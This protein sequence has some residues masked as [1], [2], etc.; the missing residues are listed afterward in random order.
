MAMT[1][2]IRLTPTMYSNIVCWSMHLLTALL[3]L[4][5]LRLHVHKRPSALKYH[6]GTR[7]FVHLQDQDCLLVGL[8]GRM[9]VASDPVVSYKLTVERMPHK[10]AGS[11]AIC[12]TYT[13]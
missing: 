1:H 3:D 13:V 6:S 9:S 11:A 4:D 7:A 2:K 5:D 10:A 8:A 12:R